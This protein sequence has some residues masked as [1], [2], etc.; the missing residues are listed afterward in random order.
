MTRRSIF[1]V[2]AFAFAAAFLFAQGSAPKSPELRV[3]VSNG[4]RE[5][6]LD[7]QPQAEKTIGRRLATQFGTTAPLMQKI[8]QG[9]TFDVA[10]LTAPAIDDLIK[11]GKIVASTRADIARAGIGI[12]IR[13][14]AARPDIHSSEAL[15]QT[16][17]KVKSITYASEGASRV[18]LEKMFDKMG[19]AADLKP[20]I[21]LVPGSVQAARDVAAGKAEI[22]MTLISEIL[23]EPGVELLGPLPPDVQNYVYFAAGVSPNAK[24]M[25]A[26][27][28]LVKF[29]SGP[30]ASPTLKA[31]GMEHH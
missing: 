14:G 20:K 8:A 22:I 12:G 2:A 7:V 6:V 16:L 27:K 3:I 11:Q 25:E 5:V 21:M 28:A 31:K 26:G 1:T 18:F 4:V 15:K 23:P 10:V 24:D 13:K 30:A 9:E 19:I 17:L 29:L